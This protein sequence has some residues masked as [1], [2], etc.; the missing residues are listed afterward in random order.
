[1]ARFL[2]ITNASAFFKLFQREGDVLLVGYFLPVSDAGYYRLAR[3]IAEVMSFP[4][5]PLYAACYP[6]FARLWQNRQL[7]ELRR[8]GWLV[9]RLTASAA[10]I[11]A[12]LLAAL[13]EPI[14]RLTVGTQYLPALPVLYWLA[15]GAA[16][17]FATAIV[18]PLLLATDRPGASLLAIG[19]GVTVQ[20]L[21]LITL[22]PRIGVVAAGVAY[23]AFYSAWIAVVAVATAQLRHTG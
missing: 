1:M 15:V 8:M 9:L 21:A 22:L 16:L 3:S 10:A 5:T 7:G 18:H 11:T 23:V 6:E 4:V 12:L 20:F 19:L 13:A 17:A 2:V 14:I